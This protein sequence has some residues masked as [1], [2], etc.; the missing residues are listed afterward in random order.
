L[1]PLARQLTATAFA[2]PP[3]WIALRLL[4]APLA[5]RV[6][7]ACAAFAA[8]YLGVSWSRG[9]LPAGWISLFA[10]RRAR[11]AAAPSEP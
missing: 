5:F 7:A 11:T 1:R 3:A 4:D 6:A 2:M 9:W 10:P 8:A